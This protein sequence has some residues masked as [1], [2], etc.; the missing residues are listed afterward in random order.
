MR[1]SDWSSDV[2]SSDLDETADLVN[3]ARL[4]I[5]DRRYL[6]DDLGELFTRDDAGQRIVVLSEKMIVA[7]AKLKSL[8]ISGGVTPE[9][10]HIVDPMNAQRGIVRP[11]DVAGVVNQNHPSR[12]RSEERRGGKMS[13]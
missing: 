4:L 5:R 11:N 3:P 2:C 10:L 7:I 13:V 12:K 8:A 1:I 6:D 9:R